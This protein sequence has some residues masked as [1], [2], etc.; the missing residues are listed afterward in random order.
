MIFEKWELIP[1][2]ERLSN[3]KS[4][5]RVYKILERSDINTSRHFLKSW[6][7]GGNTM[8]PEKEKQTVFRSARG[9]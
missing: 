8:D 3:K 2:Q 6:A 5:D 1:E 9:Q 7:A 4:I